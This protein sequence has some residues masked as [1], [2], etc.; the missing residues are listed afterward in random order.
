[1]HPVIP[2]GEVLIYETKEG[3]FAV[4]VRL[5]AET[6]WLTQKQMADLF[7]KSVK[8]I[9][10]HVGNI[11]KEKELQEES[12]IRNFRIT[13]ADGK[14]YDTAHYNLDVIISVGYRVKSP[15]GTQFRIW[16]TRML[17][18]H[19]I[20]GYTIDERRLADNRQELEAALELVRRVAHSAQLT[21]DQGKGLVDVI[22]R[23]TRT[24]LLLQQYDEGTLVEPHGREAGYVLTYNAAR[25]EIHRLRQDL[26][27]RGEAT[28]LFGQERGDALDALLGNLEQTVFGEPAYPTVESKAA[29]LL[30]FII[31]DHPLSD[32]NKRAGA[33]LFLYFLEQNR[34]LM[35]ADGTPKLND[36]GMAALALLVAESAP[37]SKETVIR[38]VMNMLADEPIPN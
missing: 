35:R 7:G 20:K 31:K 17:K 3:A 8:T 32:G 36:V 18:E 16:A 24:Y 38:L 2:H 33:C 22:T 12:V 6:V 15:Q 30:Y 21:T 5:E 1:M 14:M 26:A 27:S 29:H 11:F 28:A 25:Q 13:A 10:E 23:Y 34:A 19:L 9:N 4:D 37:N